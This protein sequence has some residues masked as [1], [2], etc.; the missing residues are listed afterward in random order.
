MTTPLQPTC[1]N[2]HPTMRND[3]FCSTCGAQVLRSP[4]VAQPGQPMSQRQPTPSMTPA[5]A[6]ESPVAAPQAAGQ[7]ATQGSGSGGSGS[8]NRNLSLGVVAVALVVAL[9][10]ALV[11][12]ATNGS[13]PKS[14]S[15]SSNGE[16]FLEQANAVGPN[17]F[18]P[19]VGRQTALGAATTT[20]AS[21]T[22]TTQPGGQRVVTATSGATPGLY[23]GTQ[24][25]S[26]CNVTQMVS[27]LQANPDKEQAWA[28]VEG[29]SAAQV[30]AY[31]QSLTPVILRAD[32]RVTNHGFYNGVATPHQSV[33]QA[34][35]AVLV[36]NYGVPRARCYCGN[37]LTPPAPVTTTPTYVNPPWPNFQPTNVVVVTP[38]PQVLTVIV[39]VDVVTGQPFDR[40]V[41]TDGSSDTNGTTTTTTT[42]SP[43]STTQSTA[44]NG[45]P[46]GTGAV[47]ITLTWS[48]TAD[49]DL[50]TVEPGG[51]EIYYGNRTAAD[52]GTLDVDSNGGCHDTTTSPVEN[53]YWATPPVAGT[54]IARPT[55][56]A[57]CPSA[58]PPGTG[59]QTFTLTIK[60]NGQV[61]QQKQGT[62]NAAGDTQDV[63]FTVG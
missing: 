9:V 35:T 8:S 47:Q 32:T 16:I 56:Y 14:A 24:N 22:T 4:D 3:K 39:V 52:G 7:V 27:Y 61:V 48:T 31:L 55:F 30:P 33:L 26:T 58:S 20:T 12:V 54:Y 11:V 42:T 51:T 17:N 18:T 50:H 25:L 63:P 2:G 41:G 57:E 6:T 29:I 19:S 45:R 43:P 36:D 49:L 10:A 59:P 21:S 37:P 34:G 62:L 53:I 60:V 38:A 23:G 13:S 28:T 46:L 1:P 5:E 15:G 40:P 44:P